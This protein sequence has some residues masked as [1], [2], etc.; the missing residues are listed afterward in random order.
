MSPLVTFVVMLVLAAAVV[1]GGYF[2]L[3]WLAVQWFR[4]AP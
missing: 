1:T 3:D 4:A 2:V